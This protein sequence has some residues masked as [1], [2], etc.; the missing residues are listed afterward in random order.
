MRVGVGFMPT[1]YA[2]LEKTFLGQ[3]KTLK[4]RHKAY[5]YIYPYKLHFRRHLCN[6]AI[7]MHSPLLYQ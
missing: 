2:Y 4:G 6:L 5:P 7:M 1:L 3:N